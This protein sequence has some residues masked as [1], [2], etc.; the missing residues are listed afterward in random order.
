MGGPTDPSSQEQTS[1]S[2]EPLIRNNEGTATRGSLTA[3]RSCGSR[4]GQGVRTLRQNNGKLE[5][6][7][8]SA[9]RVL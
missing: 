3:G 2:L 5:P 1:W 8:G 9:T 4:E 6:V 7:T